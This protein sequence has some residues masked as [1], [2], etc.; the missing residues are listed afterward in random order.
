MFF[1]ST[2]GV[3]ILRPSGRVDVQVDVGVDPQAPFLHVAVGDAQVVQQQ[4]QLGEISLGL[5][6]RTEVGLADDLQQRRAG[7]VQ[8]DAAVG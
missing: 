4:L 5:G 7:P 3:A 1:T 2:M 8:V 6:G